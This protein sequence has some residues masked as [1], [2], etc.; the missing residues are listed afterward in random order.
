MFERTD[1][2]LEEDDFE[3]R[4]QV[5]ISSCVWKVCEDSEKFIFTG[6]DTYFFAILRG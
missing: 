1:A 3:N 6:F 2:A 5:I 4:Q